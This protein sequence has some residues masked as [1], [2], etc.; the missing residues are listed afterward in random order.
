LVALSCEVWQRA[1]AGAAE[2]LAGADAD[3]DGLAEGGVEV[4]GAL[5]ASVGV[6][7]VG[8]TTGLSEALVPLEEQPAI[9]RTGSA[10]TGRSRAR[11]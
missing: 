6:V 1:P 10:A 4:A 3:G 9:A 7:L 8:V 5:E 2:L 11:G